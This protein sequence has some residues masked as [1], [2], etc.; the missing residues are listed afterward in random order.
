MNKALLFS[1]FIRYDVLDQFIRSNSSS[2]ILTQTPVDI[3]I[4][5]QSVYKHVLS[6]ELLSEDVKILSV[7]V[8]NLAAHYRHFFKSRYGINTR[9]FMVNSIQD[10]SKNI[11][12]QINA[13]NKDMF[14]IVE[15]IAPYFPLTYY[16]EKQKYNASAI[17]MNLIQTE[18]L[19]KQFSALVIS[20]D[21][22]AYQIPAYVPT[23]FL[24]RPSTNTKFITA[25]NVIDCMYPRKGSTIISDLSPALLPVI[26]AYHKC[27][28]LGMEMLNNFKKT[29]SII[30]DK[31]SRNQILNG[32]NSPIV[33]KN[34][35]EDIFRRIY[36]SD[37]MTI[38]KTYA[39]SYESLVNN[40]KIYKLCDYNV[41][42]NILDSKF[43][44][45]AENLFN[46]LFLLDIDQ[47]FFQ[48]MNS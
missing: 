7:N 3:Y 25:G 9:I 19:P 13:D 8:L 36:L 33:F 42:I 2:L 6:G 11:F 27:P 40:W 10:T 30:R 28:E 45:D 29:I 5:I 18:T 14:T 37:L 12:E 26:M 31:I 32:Y 20:N 34:E 22:Y 43:N 4:D 47:Q 44:T 15:K 46:Y 1:R 21:I 48:C 17:I 41:L 23:A 39:N 24:I 16:I 38:A 35:S